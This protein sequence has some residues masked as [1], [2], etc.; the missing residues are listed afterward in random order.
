MPPALR[1]LCFVLPCAVLSTVPRLPAA[2][3]GGVIDEVK[4]GGLAHDVGFLTHHVET[5]PDV[6]L[7]VLFT[8]PDILK[9]IGSP[10]PHIGGDINT[11]GMTGNGYFGLTW[12]ATLIEGIVNPDDGVFLN[13]SFGGAIQDGY[14]DTAPRGRKRLGSRILFRESL[15]LG[16]QVTPMISVSAM[17]DHVSNADLGRHNAG[18]TSAGGRIGFKF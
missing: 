14:I 17:L 11:N 5:G 2:A 9:V 10:R 13:G 18:I 1:V 7:E 12:S 8:S 3:G 4:L 16:Y 6:N 15:E